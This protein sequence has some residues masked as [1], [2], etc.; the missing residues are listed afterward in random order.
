MVQFTSGVFVRDLKLF[1]NSPG[2][3]REVVFAYLFQHQSR[4]PVGGQ[5]R[6][7]FG[8]VYIVADPE[9]P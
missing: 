5:S 6:Y 1:P 9:R 7:I 8:M 2:E 4:A 3:L